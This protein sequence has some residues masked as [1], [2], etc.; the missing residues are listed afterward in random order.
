[1][2][3][4]AKHYWNE[5]ERAARPAIIATVLLAL[6]SAIG[7]V[8]LV[9]TISVSLGVSVGTAIFGPG[10]GSGIFLLYFGVP[11]IVLQGLVAQALRQHIGWLRTVGALS[12]V[13]I[14]AAYALWIVAVGIDVTNWLTAGVA[15]DRGGLELE[16]VCAPLA[17]V[18]GALNARSAW[19][20]LRDLRSRRREP[21][22][23]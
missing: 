5:T 10:P 17:A 13:V 21:L 9:T 8:V 7:F 20:G 6:V 11:A 3:E 19:L 15:T 16:I 1:M 4:W 18:F 23:R 14:A 2:W 22:T 12:A